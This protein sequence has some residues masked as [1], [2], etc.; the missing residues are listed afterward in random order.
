LKNG[1]LV[2]VDITA[3]R[4]SS[5][6]LHDERCGTVVSAKKSCCD[7][8]NRSFIIVPCSEGVLHSVLLFCQLAMRSSGR[9]DVNVDVASIAIG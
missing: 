4:A 8:H 7:C 9:D 3:S 2:I 6:Q 5:L 1:V